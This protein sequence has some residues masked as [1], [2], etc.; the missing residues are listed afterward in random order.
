MK[1]AL[2]M[3]AKNEID[4]IK[5]SLAY[6]IPKVDFVIVLD[7]GSTDGTLEFLKK[8]ESEKFII[9]E[10]STP[11]GGLNGF[12]MKMILKATELGADWVINCDADEFYVGDFRSE[13]EEASKEGF[14]SLSVQTF[15]HFL[16]T[17]S[18]DL[19][20][21]NYVKRTIWHLP[22]GQKV[23]NCREQKAIHMTK[24]FSKISNGNHDVVFSRDEYK[25]EKISKNTVLHHYG[26]RGWE[27][28]KRKILDRGYL[29]THHSVRKRIGAYEQHLF[30]LQKEQENDNVLIN[31]WVR[32]YANN[33]EKLKA[34]GMV[35]ENILMQAFDSGEP[36]AEVLS[37]FK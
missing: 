15:K 8:Q 29:Y 20:E 26:Y 5:Y 23:L 19:S 28:F 17:Y 1:I 25:P 6:H 22:L 12:Y 36:A 34:M 32:L 18:D 13:I 37:S 4:I 9:L 11:T 10:D 27:H 7:N 35:Q 3:L 14:G 16:P 2:T 30:R 21:E 24:G 33:E 31:E